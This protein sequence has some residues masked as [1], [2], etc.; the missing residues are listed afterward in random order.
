MLRAQP[1]CGIQNASESA[2]TFYTV[3]MFLAKAFSVVGRACLRPAPIC[4]CLRGYDFIV[5][6]ALFHYCCRLCFLSVSF[7]TVSCFSANEVLGKLK[8]MID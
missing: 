6:F 1:D 4:F 7:E 2:L 5:C 8:S 3:Y